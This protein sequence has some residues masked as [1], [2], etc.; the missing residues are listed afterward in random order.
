MAKEPL[1]GRADEVAKSFAFG[2]AAELEGRGVVNHQD[3]FKPLGS[4]SRLPKMRTEDGI[5]RDLV[6]AEEAIRCLELSVIERLGKAGAWTQ[7]EP[8]A[9]A[10]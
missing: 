4:T 3:R 2:L 10:M 1:R 7:S 9:Q 6:V 8:L 5:R